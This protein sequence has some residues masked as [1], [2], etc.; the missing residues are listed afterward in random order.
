MKRLLL[1]LLLLTGCADEQTIAL[2]Q[3]TFV[4]PDGASRPV[5]IPVHLDHDLPD[6]PAHF[7]LRTHTIVPAAWRGRSL[8]L[9]IPLLEGAVS[10]TVNGA[11]AAAL[12][13]NLIPGEPSLTSHA[14]RVD[15]T[16]TQSGELDLELTI[17]HRWTRAGWID[18]VPRLSATE[19]GD[20]AYL[21]VRTMNGPVLLA[22]YAIMSMIGFVYLTIS[23]LDRRRVAYRFLAWQA[24]GLAY[25]LIEQLGVEQIVIGPHFFGLLMM[26]ASNVAGIYFM[27]AYFG[28]RRPN[29]VFLACALVGMAIATLSQS[30]F[31][32]AAIWFRLALPVA[33]AGSIYQTVVLLW[34]WRRGRDRFSV[35]VLL[36][37]W[38]V[39][40]AFAVPTD[41]IYYAGA[42]AGLAGGAHL[43]VIGTGFYA[44]AQGVVLGRDHNRSLREAEAANVELRRQ[45]ADRSQRLAEALA[46][47]GAVPQR[48]MSLVAGATIHG[49]W[50][51][52][53]ALGEGGMGAVYEVERTTDAKRFALKVLTSASTGVALARLA[54]EAQIAA[55]VAHEHLVAIV[56][57]DVSETGALYIVMELV[58]GAPLSARRDRY[59]DVAWARDMLAQIARGLAALHAHGVV[60]RDLKPA[61]VLVTKDGV[62]KIADFGIARLGAD[63]AEAQVAQARTE[64]MAMGGAVVGAAATVAAPAAS[65]PELTA[66]GMIMGTPLYMAPEL[67]GGAGAAAPS[68]DLFSLGVI[69]HELM[70]GALPFASPPALDAIAGRPWPAPSPLP[71]AIPAALSTILARC[72]DRDPTKRPTADEIA[73][74][75]RS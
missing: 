14:F 47:I 41:A 4:G 50:R 7:S 5:T 60:H 73:A 32:A 36:I 17:D 65:N 69:A 30:A 55:Q 23:S 43:V 13:H 34:L 51:I 15:A 21:A 49:R 16:A 26:L 45:I 8:T 28:L 62:A 66:T 67:A 74:A 59:G 44:V 70:T 33:L 25:L 63:T 56:D 57:V 61:N 72:L 6:H 24:M 18:T 39:T 29:R 40:L 58:D 75:L 22:G 52:V 10:L 1:A 20:R 11:A 68:S 9:A 64:A 37:A 46:R 53:R 42:G 38:M 27:H 2:A 31:G 3:W 48:S 54:R 71:P 12:E 19:A 35:G